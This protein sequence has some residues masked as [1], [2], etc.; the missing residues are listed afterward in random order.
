MEVRLFD[1]DVYAGDPH[2]MFTW[3]RANAPVFCDPETGVWA[4]TRHADVVWAERQPHLFSNTP[5]SRPR[6]DPQ[7][8]MIDA[9]DPYHGD[10]RRIVARGFTPK[11]MIRYEAHVHDVVEGLLDR[12][13]GLGRF[14]VVRE[15][16]RPLPM[17]LIGELLGADPSDF[18]QLQ[19]WSDQMIRGADGPENITDEVVTAAFAWG[20]WITDVVAQRRQCPGDD[21]VSTLVGAEVDGRPLDDDHVTGNALLL[22]VGGNETTRNVI[23]GGLHALLSNPSQWERLVADPELVP[24]AV[25]ECLRWVSPILNMNRTTTADVEIRGTTIP[26]G[27]SVLMEYASA[28]RDED[29]FDDPF[30]LDVGRQPNPHVAFGFGPHFCLGSSLARLEIR[31]TIDALVRRAPGLRLADPQATPAHGASTFVRGMTALEVIA[32]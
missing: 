31:A 29:V 2:P 14:D 11:Q 26:A 30:E 4:L 18:E 1:K 13:L 6:T 25:E 22:L 3:L 10:Q 23:T 28:N 7:P 8:S 20:G 9:D 12:A 32:P 15:I 21:L 16:A 5:G 27:S 17:T 19:H 24:S